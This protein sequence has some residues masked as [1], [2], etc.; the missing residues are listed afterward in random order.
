MEP[1]LN[2]ANGVLHTTGLKESSQVSPHGKQLF[3]GTVHGIFNRF[4]DEKFLH[5]NKKIMGSTAL[6]QIN[7][8]ETKISQLNHRPS[9]YLLKIEHDSSWHHTVVHFL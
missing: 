6:P 1:P 2:L 9:S 8:V 4:D 5:S 3:S 7:P